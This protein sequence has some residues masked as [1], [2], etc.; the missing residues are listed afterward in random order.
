MVQRPGVHG[1]KMRTPMKKLLIILSVLSLTWAM[2]GCSLFVSPPRMARI[3]IKGPANQ[4]NEFIF[5]LEDPTQDDM[6]IR[7]S[8]RYAI[9]LDLQWLWYEREDFKKE[10]HVAEVTNTPLA[11]WFICKYR[12]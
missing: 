5:S 10:E 6:D 11:P 4:S 2:V 12:F 9:Q 3:H 7:L 8:D 1:S